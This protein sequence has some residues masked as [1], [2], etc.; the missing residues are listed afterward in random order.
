MEFKARRDL[1]LAG[2]VDGNKNAFTSFRY[3]IPSKQE[4]TY[5]WIINKAMTFLLTP[6][7]L[8]FN[9]YISSDNECALN[10]SIQTSISSSKSSFKHSKLWLDCYH[11]YRKVWNEKNI[12]CSWETLGYKLVVHKLDTWIMK[13]FK[14]TESL[15]EIELSIKHFDRY[16]ETALTIIGQHCVEQ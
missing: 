12:P 5:T 15:N 10:S 3:F 16:L 14:Y 9:S 1:L 11:F 6:N 4:Q 7:T 2:G 8:M 13:W